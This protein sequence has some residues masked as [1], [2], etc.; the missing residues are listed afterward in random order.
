MLEGQGGA[1]GS[2]DWLL[3]I[4]ICDGKGLFINKAYDQGDIFCTLNIRHF[5]EQL[6]VSQNVTLPQL[7]RNPKNSV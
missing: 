2:T 5:K 6:A 3:Y 1:E 7:H 4:V